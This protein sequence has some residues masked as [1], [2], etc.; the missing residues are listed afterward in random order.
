L[1]YKNLIVEIN[2]R[3]CMI[4]I[5]RPQALNALNI[6]TTIE[7]YHCFKNLDNNNDI[8][9]IIVT[10]EGKSF[11]AGADISY[12][13]DLNAVEA[14]EFGLSG[15]SAFNAIENSKKVVIAALNGF[16]LGGG[17]ELAMA[18]DIRIASTKAK[19][20]QPEVTLGITPGF[21]GTQ[22]LPRIIG[23]AKAK[24]L[25]YTGNIIDA[26]EA[27]KIGLVNEVVEP[28]FLMEKVFAIANK[29]S[30]NGKFAVE[31]SKEAIDKGLQV[32]KAT[33]MHIESS[34]FG[35][36]FSSYD[37]K[38]GMSAFIEKRKSVFKNK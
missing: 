29:I 3:I 26:Q 28:E 30:S 36:C 32:D 14:K 9:V 5:N 1:K 16:T 2:D 11:I 38:E 15:I 35:L 4:R 13:K 19:L 17:C 34:L 24:E 33:G 18:C 7:I 23:V 20:G 37:Q 31:Y 10:G 27:E 22:R 12:M 6:E 8:D 25:I 21:G